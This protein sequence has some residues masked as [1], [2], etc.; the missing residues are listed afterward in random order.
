MALEI[1]G[2]DPRI[3][4]TR[5]ELF[6]IAMTLRNSA[7]ELNAAIFSPP[8]MLFDFVPNPIPNIQMAIRAPRLCSELESLAGRCDIAAENYFSTEARVSHIF[9][10]LIDPLRSLTPV[11]SIQ[12]PITNV[13]T[14]RV[15]PVVGA[16]AVAGLMARPS[17][18]STAV[19]GG[20]I[21]LAPLSAA[22]PTVQSFLAGGQLSAK[23]LGISVDASGSANLLRISVAV[24]PRNLADLATRL[25]N[26]YSNPSSALRIESYPISSGKQLVVYIPGTQSSSFGGTNPLNIR[27]NFTAMGGVV[28]APSEQAVR[29]AIEKA[30]AGKGDRVLLVGHSQGAL[31]AGNIASKTHEFEVSGLVSFAG[32][33][34][35][36]KIDVPVIAI[37]H[38]ADPV[39]LLS[40]RANPLTENWVTASSSAE[41][42]DLIAAHRIA[43][44]IETAGELDQSQD[45]GLNRIK[46]ALWPESQ[47]S[48]KQ[49][50]YQIQRY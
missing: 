44:Y 41:F 8:D 16:M 17:I 39:P 25:Q 49:Y 29:D 37:Q 12:S 4:A 45:I 30:G 36:L 24:P 27:S 2:G 6:R 19:L 18:G 13:F 34:G 5:E 20:A 40:G 23:S 1:Y 48:G 28:E 9:R 50:V 15:A 32:P 7:F 3:V 14:D 47:G 10:D 31:I 43:G 46:E 22:R 33:I 42:K 38:A 35:H 26:S 21:Q 11:L